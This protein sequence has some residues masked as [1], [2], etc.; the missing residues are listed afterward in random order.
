MGDAMQTAIV[1]KS[2]SAKIRFCMLLAPCR[3]STQARQ[4]QQH[5]GGQDGVVGGRA[6]LGAAGA[7]GQLQGGAARVAD[8]GSR[9]GYQ[10]LQRCSP[11]LIY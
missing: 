4:A 10:H 9:M 5:H 6:A 11:I 1:Q 3:L 8:C 2:T 7:G